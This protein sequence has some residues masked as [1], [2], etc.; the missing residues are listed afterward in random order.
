[1]L[2]VTGRGSKGITVT[3]Y[4]LKKIT[5][6]SKGT[7]TLGGRK[8]WIDETVGRLNTDSRGRYLGEFDTGDNLLVI[9]RDGTYELTNFELS[10][11]FEMREILLLEKYDENHVI[12]ATYWDGAQ[13]QMFAKRFYIEA[14]MPDKKYGFIS[15]ATGSKLY[16]ASTS[17]HPEIEITI[18]K[19]RKNEEVKEIIDLSEFIDIKGWKSQGN[20]LSQYEIKKVVMKAEEQLKEDSEDDPK[21]EGK[22]NIGDKNKNLKVGTQLE[23]DMDSGRKKIKDGK[24]SKLF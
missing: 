10:N 15:E 3:K 18:V 20:R 23:W 5:Q 9:Y 17:V 12:S 16:V 1:M 8:L 4:P 22:G 7:S 21:R 6:Q 13:R 14:M 2:G 11:R 19:G 24:Q